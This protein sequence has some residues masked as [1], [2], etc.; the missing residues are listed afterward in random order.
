MSD[1]VVNAAHPD[2]DESLAKEYYEKLKSARR[3]ELAEKVQSGRLSK[4]EKEEVYEILT[5]NSG[6]CKGAGRPR[7]TDRDQAFVFDLLLKV[8]KRGKSSPRDKSELIEKYKIPAADSNSRRH[9]NM[10]ENI[11]FPKLVS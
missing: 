2:F 4:T 7:T 9:C 1:I 11:A 5:G 6:D 8:L 10:P 3:L